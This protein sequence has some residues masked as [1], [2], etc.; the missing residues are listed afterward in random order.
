MSRETLLADAVEH[1]A[2]HGIGDASLRSIATAIGTSHRMLIYHFGSRDGLLAEVVRTVEQQQRDLL[3]QLDAEDLSVEQQ[4]EQFWRRVTE[5]SLVYGPLFFELSAHAMQ[6]LPHTEALKADLITVWLP[7]LTDLCVKA[8]VPPDQAPA[9]A[10]LGLAAAR[11]LL[12]D[13]LLTDDRPA[14][15]EASALLNRLFT[16]PSPS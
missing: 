16:L 8:G 13:L 14:V 4:A 7:P 6:G 9:Y 5:A 1:F 3:A 15:D 10:R 2:R 11:G 12:F